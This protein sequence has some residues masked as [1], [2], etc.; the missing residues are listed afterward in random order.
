MAIFN[1]KKKRKKVTNHAGGQAY[2]MT[3]ELRLASALLTSF[4]KDQYYSSAEDG[5]NRIVEYAEACNPLFAAKAA[6]F[7]RNEYGMRSAS[8]LIAVNL[9]KRASGEAWAKNFY[10]KIV[11]RPDDMTEI[12]AGILASGAKSPTNAMKKGFAAAFGKFD[13]YQL[14]KYR[15]EGKSVKLVDVVNLVRPIPTRKNAEALTA[16]VNG[17]LRSTNTWEAKLSAAGEKATSEKDKT[18]RKAEAWDE[19]LRSNKLGYFA[20]LRNL[21]NILTQAPDL[22]P[23]ACA[24][25]THEKAIRKSLV[26]PFRYLSAIDEV[27]KL[28][29][30][31]TRELLIALNKAVDISCANVPKFSGR[32]LVALDDSGS[33]S[34]SGNKGKNPAEIGAL[35]AAVLVKANRNCDFMQFSDSA[36]YA[37]MNPLDSTLTLARSIDFRSGG[38]NFHAIFNKA[39]K[40]YDRVIIL[41]DM[42]GWVGYNTPKESFANYCKKYDAS[43]YIYS[44]DLQGYGTMQFPEDKVFCLA[45]F[46]EKVFDTMSKLE[47][48][49]KALLAEIEKVSL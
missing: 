27:E 22:V 33:M 46:S 42:Q 41:S 13:A 32:T 16:L 29:V 39:N 18:A 40:R 8:H 17:E 45:G 9:S 28:S 11:R 37:N 36:K 48:N 25:L 49:P 44:F 7:A 5:A 35:F 12:M 23:L 38:T 6:I 2:A 47:E 14:A 19:L 20:L 3:P 21:R 30:D 15:A 24:R 26:L 4:V 34:W 31:G 43:P 1:R 10:R